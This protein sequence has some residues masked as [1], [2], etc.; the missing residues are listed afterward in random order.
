M[1]HLREGPGG[2]RQLY[3]DCGWVSTW[4]ALKTHGHLPISVPYLS[5]SAESKLFTLLL[6]REAFGPSWTAYLWD[7][8]LCPASH[9]EDQ[10]PAAR[11]HCLAASPGLLPARGSPYATQSYQPASGSREWGR[12]LEGAPVKNWT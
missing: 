10:K 8:S 1:E 9:G 5:A 7:I 3:A 2:L 6:F 12:Y 11:A 4:L